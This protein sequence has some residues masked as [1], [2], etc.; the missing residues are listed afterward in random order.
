[1]VQI[2]WMLPDDAAEVRRREGEVV[3]AELKALMA[4]S[5][6]VPLDPLSVQKVIAKVQTDD[7]A[8][9]QWGLSPQQLPV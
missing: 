3:K 6:H 1:M 7:S 2:E 5:I 9:I 4:K 8:L